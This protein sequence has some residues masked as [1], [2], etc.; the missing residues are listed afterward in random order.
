[1]PLEDNFRRFHPKHDIHF[2]INAI[3]IIKC[4]KNPVSDLSGQY[5][6]TLFPLYGQNWRNASFAVL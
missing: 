1:M 5:T 6:R 3:R 2:K 4:V